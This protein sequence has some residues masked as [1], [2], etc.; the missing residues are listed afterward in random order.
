MKFEDDISLSCLLSDG[1]VLQRGRDTKIYGKAKAQEHL[2][3]EFLG[4]A[5]ETTTTEQGKWE[6]LLYNLEAGG[7]HEMTIMGNNDKLII[8]DILIGDV[9]VC[10]GQSNMELPCDRVMD[11][12]EKEILNYSNPN[13][14][15]FLPKP[16]YNFH[17]PQEEL[18]ED[19]IWT[20]VTPDT[21]LGFTAVGYF[22]AKDLYEKYKVPIGLISAGIGG[23]PVEAWVSEKSLEDFPRL[24][25]LL[26]KCKDDSYVA[27]VKKDDERRISEWYQLIDSTDEG[28]KDESK[29]WY[30][31][32]YYD[33]EWKDFFIPQS[34]EG[35]ELEKINGSIWFR[36]E[37]DIPKAMINN[38]A[39]IF[40]G[41]I[42]DV[43]FLYINGQ[44]VGKTDDKYTPRKYNIPSGVLK[45][46]KNTIV[47][48]VISNIDIGG[49]V[50]DKAYKIV[51]NG[52][53]INLDGNWKYKIGCK[54][55]PLKGQTFF[56]FMPTGL[57][58]G[59][60]SPLKHYAIKGVI[61]YQG[62]SNTGI[63][64]GYEEL[65]TRVI[66]EWRKDWNIGECPFL[67]VQLANFQEP[68][69]EYC[70]SNWAEIRDL[71]R[72]VLKV[73]NTAMAVAIDLGEYNDLHPQNKKDVG[74]RLALA[75]EKVAYGEDVVYSGP[76]YESMEVLGNEIHV[77]FSNIGSGLMIKGNKL[78]HFAICGED[79][80]YI[81]AS[82][83]IEGE[84]V[85]IYNEKVVNPIDVRY[86][87]ADNPDKPTLYN[88]DGLPASPFSSN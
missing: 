88:K 77:H 23:T 47:V 44:F 33:S 27:N 85:K 26:N 69:K 78:E 24:K 72:K 46:G 58:N 1:M 37:I 63:T 9:W 71:Q 41:L 45:E 84:I 6:V 48:R 61:W 11:L 34:F 51:A 32:N 65:F 56:Q 79:K 81:P 80:K 50:K 16:T 25:E 7:P 29:R 76:L 17:E 15:Q 28:Y 38:S 5:Y 43:D 22:F 30:E 86:C 83:E 20:P 31:E 40:F 36:K 67:Y 53:E 10:S 73:N 39:R 3:I 4:K 52:E 82:A 14:R 21:S 8:R 70:E 62:E 75:A 54:M 42:M 87:W 12:F 60:I 18:E 66:K 35:T 68:S 55:E 13:I 49:F 19:S 64:E 59:L 74:R 57:Y 2:T